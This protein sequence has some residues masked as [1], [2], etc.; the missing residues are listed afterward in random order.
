[1]Q[2]GQ[3][4]SRIIGKTSSLRA[5]TPKEKSPLRAV[6]VNSKNSNVATGKQGY[7]DCK[8]LCKAVE[9][10]LNIPTQLFPSST[11]VIGRRLP[12]KKMLRLKNS[13]QRLIEPADFDTF[14]KAIM[15]TDTHQNNLCKN[16]RRFSSWYCKRLR[17]D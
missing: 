17:H 11:G 1:M 5:E 13:S 4:F 3:A 2:I 10:E 9:N 14:A 6:M 15:T 8:M 16:R 12:V 7:E